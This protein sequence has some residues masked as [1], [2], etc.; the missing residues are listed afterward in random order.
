MKFLL[1][2]LVAT[3]GAEQCC[4]GK[5]DGYAL[6]AENAKV[7]AAKGGIP[8]TTPVLDEGNHTFNILTQCAFPCDQRLAVEK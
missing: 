4:D 1:L 6:A 7:C 8:I 5:H 3:A 2:A